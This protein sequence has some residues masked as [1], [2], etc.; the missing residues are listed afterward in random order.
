MNQCDVDEEEKYFDSESP[1]EIIDICASNNED[2][3]LDKFMK[4]V[5]DQVMSENLVENLRNMN[6]DETI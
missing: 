3:E 1:K 4:E 2:D 5:E 6:S